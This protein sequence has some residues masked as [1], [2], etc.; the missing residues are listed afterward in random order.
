MKSTSS[1]CRVQIFVKHLALAFGARNFGL[2]LACLMLLVTG[3]TYAYA[4]IASFYATQ[5]LG[6]GFNQPY[7]V[8]VD[9]SGNVFVA[10]TYNHS[11]KEIPFSG[12]SYGTPAHRTISQPERVSSSE[13]HSANGHISVQSASDGSFAS[14]SVEQYTYVV[15][16][17]EST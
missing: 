16:F 6:S 8:A 3:E 14:W 15:L 2:M 11:V 9:G 10:D 12:G 17:H 4:Q 13:F 1:P 5:T 7:G